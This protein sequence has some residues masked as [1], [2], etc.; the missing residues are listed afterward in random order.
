MYVV[1]GGVTFTKMRFY[2]EL[3]AVLSLSGCAD[4]K[5]TDIFRCCRINVCS[6]YFKPKM[7]LETMLFYLSFAQF[8]SG[9]SD[10][11]KLFRSKPD[12]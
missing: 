10:K 9:I 2:H 3:S 12:K 1:F 8:V 5:T 7:F 4:I 6:I 11:I